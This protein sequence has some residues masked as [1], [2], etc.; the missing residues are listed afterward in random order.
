MTDDNDDVDGRFKRWPR[1][2]LAV[3]SAS[4]FFSPVIIIIIT[5][6][7][8]TILVRLIVRGEFNPNLIHR[9]K[10]IYA[11]DPGVGILRIL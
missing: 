3:V 10:Y 9:L 8:E 5:L 2:A 7:H 4:I 1:A 6:L 11:R